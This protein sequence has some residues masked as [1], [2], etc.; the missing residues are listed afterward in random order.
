MKTARIAALEVTVK[1]KALHLTHKAEASTISIWIEKSTGMRH[2]EKRIA[3]H[4][5]ITH[6]TI[7]D[8]TQLAAK[9]KCTGRKPL[10]GINDSYIPTAI[11]L[12]Q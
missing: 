12:L 10:K 6:K 3:P 4:N 8:K 1:I 2:S 11:Y 5:L 7:S 9:E